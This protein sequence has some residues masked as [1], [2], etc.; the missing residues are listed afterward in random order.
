MSEP[1]IVVVDDGDAAT[2]LAA[3]RV[4]AALRAGVEAR[5]RADWATTGGSS[6]VGIY[7][8][9]AMPEH[10]NEAPWPDVH[11]WWGD[12]RYVPRDH[13]LSNVKPFEDI[14]LDVAGREEGTSIGGS[15]PVVPLPVANVHPFRT[16]EAIG[17]GR[18]AAGCAADLA[19]ELRAANLPLLDGW[20]VFDL[21]LLGVG[22]DGHVLSVFPGSAA[23]E[24]KDW[25]LA[26]PAPTHIEP[27]VQR[28]T[29][30]PTILTVA[31]RLIVVVFG[32]GKAAVLGDIFGAEV[33]PVRWPAQLARRE[34]AT[35]ILDRVAATNLPPR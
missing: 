20:P 28:V 3:D 2:S 18:G 11:V 14:L 7:R 13:P 8:H 30:N 9:L 27:H 32:A 24:S 19:E 26:I 6:S 12:D 15:A 10:V 16:T 29:L 34:G 25:A 5:G 21:V 33:D 23:F 22:G 4:A 17:A 1:E 31:R 35:W